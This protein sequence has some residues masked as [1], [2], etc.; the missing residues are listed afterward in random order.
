MEDHRIHMK[1]KK[2]VV[3]KI[4]SSSLQHKETGDVD[5]TKLDV[6]GRS[7]EDTYALQ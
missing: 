4:G 7:E 1:D 3:V 5:Y 6:L 2:R